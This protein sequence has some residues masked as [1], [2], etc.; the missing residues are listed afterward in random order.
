MRRIALFAVFV[1]T[2]A[3]GAPAVAQQEDAPGQ[4][5]DGSFKM[6]VHAHSEHGSPG[7]AELLFDDA[8]AL[9]LDFD[10]GDSFTYSSIPCDEPAPHN[11]RALRINPDYPGVDNPDSVRHLVEGTVTEYDGRSGTIEGDLTTVHCED[12]DEGD[13]IRFDYTAQFVEAGD[14]VRLQRGTWEITE[15]T[16]TFSD[17]EGGGSLTGRLTCLPLVLEENEADSCEELGA[18][19]DAVMRLRGHWSDDTV[20]GETT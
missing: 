13:E 20:D 15:G 2:A 9:E 4:S 14:D 17:L 16:G 18:Y 8:N 19:S 12:G 6:S 10:E 11:D 7:G 3:L 1:M 5:R